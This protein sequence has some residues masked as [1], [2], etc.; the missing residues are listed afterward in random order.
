MA[1]EIWEAGKEVYELMKS[2]LHEIEDHHHLIDVQDHIAIVMKD[3]KP[4]KDPTIP[5]VTG[6]TSKAP[7]VMSA[8]GKAD[9]KF[10]ITLN[11]GEWRLF[12]HEQQR[13]Q[14]DHC[15]CAMMSKYN[16][17]TEEYTYSVRKP[18][19]VGYH[20]EL[21]RNGVWRSPP[22]GGSYP[23]PVEELFVE[24]SEAGE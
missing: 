19:F 6:K 12:E 13:A 1:A 4:P 21:Q 15:L 8:L 3:V 23:S 18:D 14:I 24:C 10:I 17:R 5:V 22:G 16:E 20:G 9:Y 7:G 11:A 2:L